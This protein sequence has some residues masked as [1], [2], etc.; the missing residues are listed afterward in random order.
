VYSSAGNP[1][2][3]PVAITLA[4][5]SLVIA[6]TF[7][8]SITYDTSMTL[9][10]QGSGDSDAFV[11]ALDVSNG[12]TQWAGAFGSPNNDSINT[13]AATPAGDVVVAGTL[14]GTM[15]GLQGA[16]MPVG[17]LGDAGT[18]TDVYVLKIDSTG[19]AT[20]N[21][22]Y[23]DPASGAYV[24]GIAYQNGTIAVAGSFSGNVNFGKGTFASTG[25]DGMV[26]TVNE[27]TKA[28]TFA[29]QLAGAATDGFTSVALD[30]WGEVVAAGR[31]G[32][33][34]ASA[35]LGPQPLQQTSLG[36]A[37]MVLAKWSPTGTLLWAH[38]YV[39]TLDGGA[40]P[41]LTPDAS[42]VP[43]TIVPVRVQTTSTGLI[44]VTG[45]MVGGTDF[46]TG[47][48]G[49]V[50]TYAWGHCTCFTCNATCL[51]VNP[52]ACCTTVIPGWSADGI[53]GVWQP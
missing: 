47:Y 39:P 5:S 51:I 32:N 20:Y 14:N 24:G 45:T 52:P 33:S 46:G 17:Q 9:N 4:G 37:G 48:E 42:D 16:G 15:Q 27:T 34:N 12:T 6:V 40:P 3:G 31:Y 18:G 11:T 22:V 41:Y 36:T 35:Q 13:I 53:V 21:L 10:S 23:G 50:S 38:G 19:K 25:A 30:P 44:V 7:T 29:V 49:Q 2:Y 8:G 43:Q 26:F 28:T 1:I